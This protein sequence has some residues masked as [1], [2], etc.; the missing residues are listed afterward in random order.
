M[1]YLSYVMTWVLFCAWF[2]LSKSVHIQMLRLAHVRETP[3]FTLII[4]IC[5]EISLHM[6]M[7]E[8]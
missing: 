6:E 1:D 3:N 2:R 8:A 5:G 4:P 7:Q